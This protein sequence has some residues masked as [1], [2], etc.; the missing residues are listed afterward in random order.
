MTKD[1]ED[2]WINQNVMFAST[3]HAMYAFCEETGCNFND[4]YEAYYNEDC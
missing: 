1:F 3:V 4:L 2:W